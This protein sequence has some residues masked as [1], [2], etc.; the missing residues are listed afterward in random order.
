MNKKLDVYIHTIQ[1]TP[2]V[3]NIFHEKPL[4]KIDNVYNVKLLQ[5][6]I[7]SFNK[8]IVTLLYNKKTNK[9]I[10]C[11]TRYRDRVYNTAYDI[12]IENTEN[13]GIKKALQHDKQLTATIYR[14]VAL[15]HM[16]SYTISYIKTLLEDTIM[17]YDDGYKNIEDFKNK[18]SHIANPILP[19]IGQGFRLT[20]SKIRLKDTIFTPMRLLN[21][22][23]SPNF[24]YK[25]SKY[26]ILNAN[27]REYPIIINYD[28]IGRVNVLDGRNR[29]FHAILDGVEE[30]DVFLAYYMIL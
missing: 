2:V 19:P 25:R 26:S 12:T 24:T 16:K 10:V 21:D 15:E 20:K 6:T 30:L 27:Y 23:L 9:V 18:N 1:D 14:G 5:S 7:I 11:S 29:L 4:N 3:Y 13:I 22:V 28:N 17:L 8:K